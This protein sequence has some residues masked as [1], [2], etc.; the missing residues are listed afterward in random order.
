LRRKA[1]FAIAGNGHFVTWAGPACCAFE[2]HGHIREGDRRGR[3]QKCQA[4][5]PGD[6]PDLTSPTAWIGWP[7]NVWG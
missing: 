4:G 3:A 1:H 7:A 6:D 5:Y 2:R